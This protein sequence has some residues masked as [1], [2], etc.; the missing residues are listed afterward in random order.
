MKH[1]LIILASLLLVAVM[2]VAIGYGLMRYSA[3]LD[4]AVVIGMGPRGNMVYLCK[5]NLDFSSNSIRA[6][7]VTNVLPSRAIITYER[8]R[9]V[10]KNTTVI[11]C[12]N[13]GWYR[14]K[15]CDHY[16][17]P[18]R[19]LLRQAADTIIVDSHH[20][21]GFDTDMMLV[22]LFPGEHQPR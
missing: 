4:D 1:L 3:S 20:Y 8:V 11:L 10:R 21:W 15:K 16:D 2:T 13:N 5:D 7:A 12:A 17:T 18:S 14:V 9:Y 19:N 22:Q 6:Y